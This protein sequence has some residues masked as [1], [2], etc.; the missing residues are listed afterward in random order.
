VDISSILAELHTE[1][2]RVNEAIQALERPKGVFVIPLC[3]SWKY[4]SK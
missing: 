2:D 1:L 3:E 4:Y